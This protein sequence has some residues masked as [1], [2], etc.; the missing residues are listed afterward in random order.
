[1]LLSHG[2]PINFLPST[3]LSDTTLPRLFCPMLQ[4]LYIIN[5]SLVLIMLRLILLF[6][7]S[8]SA[9]AGA[10][11]NFP[12]GGFY[13]NFWSQVQIQHL[14][15]QQ[16]LQSQDQYR[17]FLLLQDQQRQIE[18]LQ[19]QQNQFE[20]LQR[21]SIMHEHSDKLRMYSRP[22]RLKPEVVKRKRGK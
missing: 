19:D 2:L 6:F 4:R 11:L 10:R 18:Q 14:Q 21:N 5:N 7:T 3:T 1:M 9:V 22:V 12:P 13:D 8:F 20:F 15:T 17:R 16:Q